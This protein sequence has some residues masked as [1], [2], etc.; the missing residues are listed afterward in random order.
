ME[1]LIRVENLSFAYE[2]LEDGTVD[3]VLENINDTRLP[4]LDQLLPHHFKP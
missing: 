1:E 4:N 3:Y 2:T